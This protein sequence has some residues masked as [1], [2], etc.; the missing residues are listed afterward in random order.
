MSD[1]RD[2]WD[3]DDEDTVFYGNTREP[4]TI[5]DRW[6][7]AIAARGYTPA[8]NAFMENYAALEITN[9]EAMF[10]MQLMYHKR[11]KKM[12]YPKFAV[13]AKRMGITP[14]A[15]RN[16]ARSLQAK[17]FIKRVFRSGSTNQFDLKP[18]FDAIEQEMQ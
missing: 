4:Q 14:T 12:P 1:I 3:E 16:H 10:L 6:T 11:S 9:S 8:A 15:A 7:P 5:A 18:L 2:E 17:G 13:I